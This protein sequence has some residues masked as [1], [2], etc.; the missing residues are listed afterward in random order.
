MHIKIFEIAKRHLRDEHGVEVVAAY[1]SPSHDV[2]V[3]AKLGDEALCAK[4]R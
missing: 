1:I 4:D 2:H 3:C